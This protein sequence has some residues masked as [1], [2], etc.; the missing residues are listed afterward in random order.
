MEKINNHTNI[1]HEFLFKGEALI[2]SSLAATPIFSPVER[3]SCRTKEL[4]EFE[5]VRTK[6]ERITFSGFKLDLQRDYPLFHTIMRH[7]QITGSK[8]FTLS[9]KEITTELGIQNRSSN[10]KDIDERFK[11]MMTC[12]FQIEKY[13]NE[14]EL[15]NKIYSNLINRV[16]WDIKNKLFN[17]EIS[18]ELYNAEQLVDYEVLNLTVFSGLKSQY[19]R[20][21]F[22]FYETFK[23]INQESVN[24]SIDKLGIR[25]GK[26]NMEKKHLNQEIKK[27]NNE[28]VEKKYLKN[29]EYFT[30]KNH[31]KMCKISR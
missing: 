27:A 13:N 26:N 11:K 31:S 14:G 28:L 1:K 21:L 5:L 24:F 7:K 2:P 15:T 18:D 4:S 29:V 20:A 10:K 3:K 6:N 12:F 22:L 19:A 9:E 16:D 25:L 30:A 8:S 17:I 23:F